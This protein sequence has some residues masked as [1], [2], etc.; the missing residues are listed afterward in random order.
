MPTGIYERTEE[1][2]KKMSLAHVGKAPSKETKRKLS[3]VMLDIP[4][5]KIKYKR[6]LSSYSNLDECWICTSHTKLEKYP[7]VA[8]KRKSLLMSHYIYKK[9]YKTE[10]PKGVCV[11]HKCDKTRC[12]NPRHLFLGTQADNIADMVKKERQNGGRRKNK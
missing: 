6:I 3:L 8:R 10:I 7:R 12:I 2:K 9:Y 1:T 11:L 5:K 4:C